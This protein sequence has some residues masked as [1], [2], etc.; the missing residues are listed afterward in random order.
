MQGSTNDH[1]KKHSQGQSFLSSLESNQNV[2]MNDLVV[3]IKIVE[4]HNIGEMRV[5]NEALQPY[6]EMKLLPSD[7]IAGEQLQRTSFRSNPP[8]SLVQWTPQESFTFL[9]TKPA[10][11]KIRFSLVQFNRSADDVPFGDVNLYLKGA[12]PHKTVKSPLMSLPFVSNRNGH[13][14]G[15][16]RFKIEYKTFYDALSTYEERV[17]EYQRFLPIVGHG[18]QWGSK[19][20]LLPT[21]PG[22]WFN[23]ETQTWGRHSLEEVLTP[24]DK[25]LTV[26]K[27]WHTVASN[28]E[29]EPWSYAFDFKSITWD[30]HQR[31]NS[32]VRRRLWTRVVSR[33][34][35][36]RSPMHTG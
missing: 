6:V 10:I 7:G 20:H 34:Y 22:A 4:L 33:A 1:G 28:D 31:P 36:I 17:F 8:E 12:D 26:V 27:N 35:S 15:E 29:S 24:N 25:S 13:K 19:D 21:D 18:G 3:V 16:I 9:V 32:L 2:H 5:K 11:S 14:L 30:S 23:E